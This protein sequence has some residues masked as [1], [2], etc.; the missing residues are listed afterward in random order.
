LIGV[1]PAVST[2]GMDL[3]LQNMECYDYHYSLVKISW[4]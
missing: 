1:N 4:S 3:I 2:F